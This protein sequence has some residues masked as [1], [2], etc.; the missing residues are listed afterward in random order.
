MNIMTIVDNIKYHLTKY[1]DQELYVIIKIS[2]PII[3]KR[4]VRHIN[5]YIIY[6]K[7]Y[8]V[9]G[10]NGDQYSIRERG[11]ANHLPKVLYKWFK[12]ILTENDLFDKSIMHFNYFN[13]LSRIQYFYSETNK[14][15]YVD[16]RLNYT[17]GVDLVHFAPEL[18]L[19]EI[20]KLI[21]PTEY[22]PINKKK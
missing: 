9:T 14:T 20:D 4:Y 22:E 1:C 13:E 5:V 7:Y 2:L 18:N 11:N 12:S 8:I 21:Y 19:E 3:S 17:K 6:K 16:G 10:V 15:C